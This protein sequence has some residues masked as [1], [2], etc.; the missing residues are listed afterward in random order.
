MHEILELS[1]VKHC[2]K[3]KS[4]KLCTCIVRVVLG[5]QLA[6]LEL[7]YNLKIL[8]QFIVSSLSLCVLEIWL[9]WF[10]LSWK[11]HLIYLPLSVL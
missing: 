6:R 8:G 11:V 3:G 1:R 4:R 9:L 5:L 2:I 7:E 10:I